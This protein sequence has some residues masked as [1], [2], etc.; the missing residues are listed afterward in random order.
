MRQATQGNGDKMKKAIAYLRRSTRGQ[1]VSFEIQLREIQEFCSRHNYVLTDC[2]RDSKS[3]RGNQRQGFLEA[4]GRVAEDEELFLI[5][6]RVDRCARNLGSL[7]WLEPI[8][9]RLRSVELG[10]AEIN[11]FVL[12][13]LLAVAKAESENISRRVRSAYKTLKAKD[14]NKV[15]GSISG[16]EKG[17]VA[18]REVREGVADLFLLELWEQIEVLGKPKAID[19]KKHSKTGYWTRLTDKLNKLNIRTPRGNH[20]RSSNLKTMIERGIERGLIKQDRQ[21]SLF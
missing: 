16:L 21:V 9:T 19:W 8:Q 5:V 1:E 11:S 13:S 10:D 12:T 6:S 17:R 20:F 2:L 18:S 7:N 4:V 14:P 3:G 15:W